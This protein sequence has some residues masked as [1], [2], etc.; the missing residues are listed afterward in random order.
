M[1]RVLK[2][3]ND[4]NGRETFMMLYQG[5]L[6]GGNGPTKAMDVRRSEVRILDKFKAAGQVEGD[7]V[8][9]SQD[10]VELVLEQPELDLLKKYFEATGWITALSPKVVN[11]SDWMTTAPSESR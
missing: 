4:D 1:M 8:V 7:Q 3:K 11:I 10:T 5:F 2:F 9:F 6:S